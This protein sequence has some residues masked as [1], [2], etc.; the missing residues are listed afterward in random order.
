[1]CRPMRRER[2]SRFV[3]SR[4]EWRS[5]RNALELAEAA[6]DLVALSIEVFI[7]SALDSAIASRG[8]DR[9]GA[10][11]FDLARPGR[12]NRIPYRR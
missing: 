12:R 11:G 10:D 5:G 7:I 2:E 6:F 3:I 8:N 1:M 4:S 9:F